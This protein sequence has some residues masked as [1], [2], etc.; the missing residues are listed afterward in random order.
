M[1]VTI[2]VSGKGVPGKEIK[3]E[4]AAANPTLYDV[5]G[6]AQEQHPEEFR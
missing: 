6:L 3:V 5:M 2:K 1:I 4:V